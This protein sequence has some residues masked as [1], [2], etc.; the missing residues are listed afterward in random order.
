VRSDRE[1]LITDPDL[2]DLAGRTSEYF[3]AVGLR[4]VQVTGQQVS[5]FSRQHEHITCLDL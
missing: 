3:E 5:S 4:C 1:E 2:G